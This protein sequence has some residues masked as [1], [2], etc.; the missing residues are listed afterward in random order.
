MTEHINGAICRLVATIGVVFGLGGMAHGFFESLQGYVPTNGLVIHA[1]GE[2]HRMWAYG[3][4]PAFT[5]IPNFLVTGIA[6]ML[7]GLVI[8]IWSVGF[9][10]QKNGPSVFLKLFIVSFFVGGG[11]GQVIFFTMGWTFATFIHKPL[12]RWEKF[13]SSRLRQA[14]SG[15][16]PIFTAAGAVLILYTLQIAIFGYVPGI[17]NPDTVSMVMV[18]TLGLGFVLWFLAFISSMAY[19]MKGGYLVEENPDSVRL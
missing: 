1:I 4:E 9:L 3:N 19:D 8:I 17:V 7:T 16:W 14:I 5:I 6:A 13:M 10:H 11:I 12:K 18:S 2:T 15:L